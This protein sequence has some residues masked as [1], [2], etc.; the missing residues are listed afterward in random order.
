MDNKLFI[1]IAIFF[2]RFVYFFSKSAELQNRVAILSRQSNTETL[3]IRILHRR[4]I[5]EGIETV[6]L[7]KKLESGLGNLL[8]YGMHL[9]KQVGVIARSKVIIIDGYCIPVS[10]LPKKEG[11]KV[12]QMWHALGAIKK[13]GWQSVDNPDGHSK[14]VAELMN[15]HGNYDYFL[16]PCAVT[17]ASFAEGFRTDISKAVY[18]GL[19]RLDYIC[20][21]P[22]DY[23]DKIYTAYPK[24]QDRVNVLY[25]PTFRKNAETD[26]AALIKAFDYDKYNLIIK[27][28]FLDKGDYTWA[29]ELG[30]IVDDG[31]NSLEWLKLCEKVITD[32]SAISFEAAAVNKELY[33]YQPD[34]ESYTEKVGLNIDMKSEAIGKYVCHRAEELAGIIGLPYEKKAVIEF[35]SKYLNINMTNCSSDICRFIHNLLIQ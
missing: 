8:S 15:M 25:V 28:H 18:L 33:I 31:F 21:E 19:P 4:L 34:L 2:L 6:V 27:K 14:E 12:I 17:A 9:M 5:D 1:K 20:N 29:E 32:Y 24:V 3:D 23:A 35:R 11:Q 30:A 22:V 7:T 26:M 13:F 16:A 10:V